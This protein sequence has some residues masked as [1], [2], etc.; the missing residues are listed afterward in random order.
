MTDNVIAAVPVTN[1]GTSSNIYNGQVQ[2]GIDAEYSYGMNPAGVTEDFAS[3]NAVDIASIAG[4]DQL[5]G[6]VDVG[7]IG[8]SDAFD[9]ANFNIEEP[10]GAS[11]VGMA[12]AIN[13]IGNVDI[14]QLPSDVDAGLDASLADMEWADALAAGMPAQ[15]SADWIDEWSDEIV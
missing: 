6:G 9:V 3:A 14:G 5:R 8:Y 15:W 13:S 7:I 1:F 11:N 12:S 10:Q 2:G 4:I